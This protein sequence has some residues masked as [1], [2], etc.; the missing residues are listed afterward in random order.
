[1]SLR[2]ATA[3]DAARLAALH[4]E[5]FDEPWGADAFATLL[6]GPGGYGLLADGGF[7]LCRAIA[8]EAEI[9]TLAVTPHAR[10]Q[11]LGRTLVEAAAIMAAQG[12][13]GTFFLEVASDNAAAISLYRAA[14]FE[15]AGARTG[16]YQRPD[17]A[18]DALVMRRTLNT[19]G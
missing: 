8:G 6:S 19:D 5:A 13:A 7:I 12:G 1:M 17:G 2:I 14:G 10:R 4:A 3:A 16:Y 9:L 18:V 11:G 15:R